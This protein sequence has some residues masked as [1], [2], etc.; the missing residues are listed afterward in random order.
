MKLQP[1]LAVI[2]L[3]VCSF[4]TA[5]PA[6]ATFAGDIVT[7]NYEWPDLG[8]V[9]YAGGSSTIAAGGTTFDMSSGGVLADVSSSNI[10][11]TFPGGW[12][13]ST[14]PKT[15]DGVVVTDPLAVITGVSLASTNIAGFVAS[16]L[17]FDANNVY[18]D[19][20]FPPF[21]SLDAGASVSADVQF[22][23]PVPEPKSLYLTMAVLALLLVLYR[24]RAA[25]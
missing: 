19:F 16:D 18:I 3:V 5:I 17:S 13:F 4:A 25:V 9:L 11:L 8:T 23:S 12:G 14:A 15:F 2:S 22:A 10:L 6:K 20:P 24:R 21:S 1:L 7:V